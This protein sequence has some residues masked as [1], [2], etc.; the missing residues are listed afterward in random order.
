MIIKLGTNSNARSRKDTC[1]IHS[2]GKPGSAWT[3]RLNM[4]RADGHSGGGKIPH[5]GTT[6]I[7]EKHGAL[8]TPKQRE[9]TCA[10]PLSFVKERAEPYGNMFTETGDAFIEYAHQALSSCNH[11]H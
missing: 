10:G 11:C 1:G 4:Y 2:K 9:L 3:C 6:K 5:T 7:M 8:P